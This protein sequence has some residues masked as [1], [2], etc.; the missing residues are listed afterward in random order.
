[1]NDR[2]TASILRVGAWR[3]LLTM[4]AATMTGCATT[5]P[6]A[7]PAVFEFPAVSQASADDAPREPRAAGD[8][9]IADRRARRRGDVLTV[10]ILE[11][12]RVAQSART[13]G[14]R[15]QSVSGDLLQKDGEMQRW[16]GSLGTDYSGG[17]S[18]ERS[19]RLLARLAVVVEGVDADGN[20]RVR[21][22]Q[23]IVINSERQ[24]M[25]LEGVVRPDD[26]AAD[27]TIPSWR[28]TGARISLT[29]QGFLSRKQRPGIIQQLLALLGV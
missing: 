11:D 9:F 5:A 22:A 21:G 19:G 26:I 24:E 28:I 14:A 2:T 4:T 13:R 1:M 17:G 7:A 16:R 18:I 23:D 29:G 15:D 3:V 25:R 20:L 27:N 6:T 12:A 8:S 10:I